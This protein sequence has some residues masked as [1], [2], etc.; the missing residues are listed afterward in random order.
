MVIARTMRSW[1]KRAWRRNPLFIENPHVRDAPGT[2][3]QLRNFCISD[4]SPR[5][6]KPD[7]TA[8][9]REDTSL[10]AKLPSPCFARLVRRLIFGNTGLTTTIMKQ[11]ILSRA[12]WTRDTATR[13]L[14][15]TSGMV[16][17]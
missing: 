1:L 3:T 11:I 10:P 17:M 4:R 2:Q 9:I 14:R 8:G 12:D 7:A 15:S 6:A 13:R 16:Q 5:R